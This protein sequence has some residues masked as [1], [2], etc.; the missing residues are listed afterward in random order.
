M[1][2]RAKKDALQE[3]RDLLVPMLNTGAETQG[4]RAKLLPLI[5]QVEAVDEALEALS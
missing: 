5:E 2:R 4:I 1:L 3:L